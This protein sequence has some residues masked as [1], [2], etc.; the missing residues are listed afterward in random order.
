VVVNATPSPYQEMRIGEIF[1]LSGLSPPSDV[2]VVDELSLLSFR[3]NARFLPSTPFEETWAPLLRSLLLSPSEISCREGVPSPFRTSSSSSEVGATHLLPLSPPLLEN[4]S[5]L[6]FSPQRPFPLETRRPLL[7]YR[8]T[9]IPLPLSP[10]SVVMAR[11]FFLPF[12]GRNVLSSPPLP[13]GDRGAR[14]PLLLAVTRLPPPLLGIT[15]AAM[16]GGPLF[17]LPPL[18]PQEGPPPS[19]S[20]FLPSSDAR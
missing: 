8:T 10:P 7:L 11:A 5:F 6:S 19:P 20:P 3:K 9:G 17:S 2:S 16:V 4:L 15:N 12:L 14:L 1:P 13:G 18:A